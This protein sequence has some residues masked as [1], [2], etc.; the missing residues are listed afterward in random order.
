MYYIGMSIRLSIWMDGW[1]DGLPYW[2]KATLMSIADGLK[3]EEPKQ[4]RPFPYQCAHTLPSG[5]A[6]H[7][8]RHTNVMPYLIKRVY[9]TQVS[10][11]WR[12]TSC[13]HPQ[14]QKETNMSFGAFGAGAAAQ[15]N[16]NIAMAEQELV[17]SYP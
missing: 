2:M 4:R 1:M 3:E 13:Q 16:L 7:M 10:P 15:S 8:L 5:V 12:F 17:R 11:T 6:S 9:L 14:Y